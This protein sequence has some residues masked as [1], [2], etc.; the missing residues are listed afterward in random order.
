MRYLTKYD[1]PTLPHLKIGV[2]KFGTVFPIGLWTFP[3]R[4]KIFWQGPWQSWSLVKIGSSSI[5]REPL[6]QIT[7]P[8]FFTFFL[9]NSGPIEKLSYKKIGPKGLKLRINFLACP[10]LPPIWYPNCLNLPHLSQIT[11]P[12]KIFSFLVFLNPIHK[13]ASIIWIHGYLHCC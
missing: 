10:K 3:L 8:S 2:G 13:L 6:S 9:S 11:P 4:F 5:S 7:P 12:T 1:C